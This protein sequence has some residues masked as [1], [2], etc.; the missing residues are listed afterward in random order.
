M[1]FEVAE[2]TVNDC[3]R[4][5]KLLSI[6][7]KIL[8]KMEKLDPANHQIIT[9]DHAVACLHKRGKKFRY[10]KSLST[11]DEK[12]LTK[13]NNNSFVWVKYIPCSAEG[14]P[15]KRKAD[16]P[17][18]AMVCDLIAPDGYA[19]ILGTAEKITDY[20]E[21][22]ERM[23]EKGKDAP[24]Q[25]ERYQDYLNLRKYGLPEHGGIGMGIERAVR[26]LLDLSHVRYTRPF[27]IVHGTKVNF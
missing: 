17:N 25:L 19:E 16:Q 24:E 22:L 21:L 12:E 6:G 27:P 26:Y 10:G 8:Q 1:L 23:A 20:N 9:Y 14:F 11:S 4:E 2:K 5:I 15:F 3:Q 13:A 7:D 18:L